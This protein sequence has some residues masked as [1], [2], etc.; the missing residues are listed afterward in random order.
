M[1]FSVKW[2]REACL[3]T[4]TWS[5]HQAA[6]AAAGCLEA[7]TRRPREPH[8]LRRGGSQARGV[9][10]PRSPARSPRGA[11]RVERRFWRL[12]PAGPEAPGGQGK[13]WSRGSLRWCPALPATGRGKASRRLERAEAVKSGTV[14]TQQGGGGSTGGWVGKGQVGRGRQAGP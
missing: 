3:L 4:G 11:L 8:A 13:G 10:P 9:R 14:A 2:K 5:E 12:P 6:K 1:E 7:G